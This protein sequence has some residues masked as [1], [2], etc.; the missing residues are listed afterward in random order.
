M[1]RLLCNLLWWTFTGFMGLMWLV[2]LA[3]LINAY[4]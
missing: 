1:R 4:A 2:L 3:M